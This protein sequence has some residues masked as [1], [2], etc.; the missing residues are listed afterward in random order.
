MYLNRLG[1]FFFSI[2]L[3]N[4]IFSNQFQVA[5]EAYKNNDFAQAER[6]YCMLPIKTS[7]ALFNM[8]L[9]AYNQKLYP[10][11]ISFWRVACLYTTIGN[12]FS[13]VQRV[14]E[15]IERVKKE[16]EVP[17][18]WAGHPMDSKNISGHIL[19]LFTWYAQVMPLW[20]IQLLFIVC[21]AIM[22]IGLLQVFKS[23]IRNRKIIGIICIGIIPL[24]CMLYTIHLRTALYG[25][26]QQKVEL[27]QGPD[28]FFESIIQ[29]SPLTEVVIEEKYSSWYKV[30]YQE[31]VGWLP[32][33][34][35]Y[36]VAHDTG[37]KISVI[38][39]SMH[40]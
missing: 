28:D 25:V 38:D 36:S 26:V 3:T 13:I 12:R 4:F 37:C 20:I 24:Y 39:G 6:L 7:S 33:S 23:N 21:S 8:G 27:R 19:F 16:Q 14:A 17:I 11:A 32:E 18:E 22:A 29:V 34:T 2:F 30:K 10:K 1:V 9:V 40:H 35:V 15:A 5:L 31:I